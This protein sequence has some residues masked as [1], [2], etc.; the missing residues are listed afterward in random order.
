LTQTAV[1]SA[2]RVFK[3]F[4]NI[5]FHEREE[6]LLNSLVAF[7]GYNGTI[8]WKRKLAPG[9]M[10]HRSTMIASPEILYVGDDKSCML[11]DTTT[12]RLKDEIIPPEDV[13][14]GTFWK[15]MAIEDDTL[16]ALI[17]EQEQKEYKPARESVG[18]W[19]KPAGY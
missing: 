18:I 4:G 6:A 9:V 14:G 5:A 17:G 16:Y 1:A 10:I 12:G 7:N 2:G 11:I 3:A 19:P 15:W 13:A 8:L